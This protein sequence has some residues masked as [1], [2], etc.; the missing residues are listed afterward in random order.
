NYAASYAGMKGLTWNGREQDRRLLAGLE[1]SA[2]VELA[3]ELQ[4][5]VTDEV[6]D[7]AVRR[8]PKEYAHIDPPPPTPHL[9]GRPPRPAEAANAYYMPLADKVKVSL[10][11]AP[12]LVQ[13]ERPSDKQARVRVF[14]RGANGAAEGEPLYDRT[15]LA[16]ETSEVQVYL[17]AGDDKVETRG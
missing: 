4:A 17:G 5:H 14:R 16:S 8:M 2:Y 13:V 1:R 15:L 3:K 10:S 12:E 11:G 7:R 6:I 9:N